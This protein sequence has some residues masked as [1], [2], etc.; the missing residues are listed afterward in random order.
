MQCFCSGILVIHSNNVMSLQDMDAIILLPRNLI[1]DI[2][3]MHN[4][5]HS[6]FGFCSKIAV[7]GVTN[8]K[9]LQGSMNI[10]DSF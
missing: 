5:P 6:D 10:Y 8:V 2:G 4:S 7:V 1:R 3:A 9:P